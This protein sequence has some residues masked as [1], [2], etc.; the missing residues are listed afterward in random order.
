MLGV[1]P[2]EP[3][4]YRIRGPLGSAAEPL[5]R[6]GRCFGAGL[7]LLGR[8]EADPRRGARRQLEQSCTRRRGPPRSP[9]PFHGPGCG[10]LRPCARCRTPRRG[11]NGRA[12]AATTTPPTRPPVASWPGARGVWTRY[13]RHWLVNLP[14]LQPVTSWPRTPVR[15]TAPRPS[16]SPAVTRRRSSAWLLR[17]RRGCG[18]PSWRVGPRARRPRPVIDARAERRKG[19]PSALRQVSAGTCQ[20]ERS[21]PCRGRRRPACCSSRARR[22]GA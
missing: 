16:A 18:G 4:E 21:P 22:P 20:A 6:A 19:R 8:E 17:R 9:M 2:R 12:R 14:S 13:V 5:A 11:R 1:F 15:S 10:R 3:V 7:V